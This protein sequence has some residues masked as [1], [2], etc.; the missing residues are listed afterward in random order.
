MST[1]SVVK[2]LSADFI[3]VSRI[4]DQ[5]VEHFGNDKLSRTSFFLI[6][7]KDLVRLVVLMDASVGEWI[8]Y[9]S[10]SLDLIDIAQILLCL[11]KDYMILEVKQ[12]LFYGLINGYNV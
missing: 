12:D 7:S 6:E 9:S 11:N 8:S 4:A 5:I 2:V 3:S 10:M 1:D